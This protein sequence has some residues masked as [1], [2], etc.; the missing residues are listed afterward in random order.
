[1]TVTLSRSLS[2]NVDLSIGG[3]VVRRS[4][5]VGLGTLNAVAFDPT[6]ALL[7]DPTRISTKSVRFLRPQD[8]ELVGD[9]GDGTRGPV[10]VIEEFPAPTGDWSGFS[11][12]EVD[13][14]GLR[15]VMVRRAG[16]E[17][18]CW[19]T[20]SRPSPA[21]NHEPLAD[22]TTVDGLPIYSTVPHIVLPEG[23]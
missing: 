18:S 1:R 14:R 3:A 2:W 4:Q 10:G 19:V 16:T 9:R 5:F 23:V 8:A 15:R 12:V 13:V 6:G 22:V 11:L 21:L 7:R 17:R 20:E